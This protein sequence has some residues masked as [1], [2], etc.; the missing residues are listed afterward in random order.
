MFVVHQFVDREQP[1]TMIEVCAQ[2]KGKK[3]VQELPEFYT[4]ID[5]SKYV[6]DLTFFSQ[7][8]RK[9]APVIINILK[10]L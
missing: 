8:V 10:K 5:Y 6:L 1:C 3:T 9:L 7:I 2:Q 4:K